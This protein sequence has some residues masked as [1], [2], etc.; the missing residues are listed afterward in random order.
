M[1]KE[2]WVTVNGKHMLVSGGSG[3]TKNTSK[4]DNLKAMKTKEEKKKKK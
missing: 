2:E 4:L 1:S 3:K